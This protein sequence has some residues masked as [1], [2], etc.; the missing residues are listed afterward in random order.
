MKT[1]ISSSSFVEAFRNYGRMDN[2][3]REGLEMLFDYFEQ[4]EQDCGVEMELDVIGI[5]CD[6][7]ESSIES[8]IQDYDIDVSE[9]DQALD[10]ETKQDSIK[11][12]V[13][14][15]LNDNTSVVGVT[16]FGDVIYQNF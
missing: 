5:C 6:F 4:Y 12:I 10:E 13:L 8:I 7:S 14:E 1:T 9:A 2:F 16:S 15:Y 11:E 3:S